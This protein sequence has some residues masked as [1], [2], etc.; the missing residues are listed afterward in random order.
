MTEKP[1]VCKYDLNSSGT[2]LEMW[3]RRLALIWLITILS[4]DPIELKSVF[5]TNAL[6]WCGWWVAGEV[7]IESISTTI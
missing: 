5:P 7:G 6:G 1:I 4:Q 3:L 2:R